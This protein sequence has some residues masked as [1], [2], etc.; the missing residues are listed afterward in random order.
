LSETKDNVLRQHRQHRLRAW[1]TAARFGQR[2]TGPMI[3]VAEPVAVTD[4]TG[5]YLR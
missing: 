2:Q 3:I 4:S 1:W 5:H